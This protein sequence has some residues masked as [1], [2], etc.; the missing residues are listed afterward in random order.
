MST[1]VSAIENKYVV[2][3]GGLGPPGPIGPPGPRAL[4]IM[5]VLP[6]GAGVVGAKV[7]STDGKRVLSCSADLGTVRLS[8]GCEGATDEYTPVCTVGT[9]PVALTESSTKRW[10]TG[11]VDVPIEEGDNTV[12]VTTSS[13]AQTSVDISRLGAGPSVVSIVIGAYPGTQTELKQGDVLPITVNTAPEAVEVSVV[14][15][16]TANAV[17][18]PVLDGVATGDI[19]IGSASGNVTFQVRAK[20]SFGTYGN[21]STSPAIVLNQTYPSF[22]AFNVTYPVGQSALKNSESA[23]VSCT[24]TNADIVVYSATGLDIPDQIYS[25]SKTVTATSAAYV[26]TGNNYTI[27]ATRVAN[28]ATSVGNTLVKLATA[29]PT[30]TITIANSPARLPSS[31][32][33]IDYEIRITPD[34]LLISSPSLSASTGTWQGLWTT[35]G[36]YWKRNLRITDASPRGVAT[37]SSLN[38]SSISN[39]PGSVISSGA[40]YTIGGLS[41]RILALPAFS[42]VVYLGAAVSMENKTT[43]SILAGA[44][45]VRQSS[46]AYVSNGFYIANAD[47]SYNPNGEYVGLSNTDLTSANTSGTLQIQFEEVL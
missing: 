14:Y 16:T 23:T 4:F 44:A 38:L 1:L 9:I 15:S 33:G 27:T 11:T 37:F 34:Q 8:I 13:G 25:V 42:R 28:N 20:N 41:S 43:C 40:N 36:S 32:S 31:P 22:S 6:I 3:T 7:L 46:N 47:G 19:T 39:T 26:A 10:F 30:A 35:S 24:V 45:L 2:V 5:D 12:L 21:S 18:I 17:N 29:A